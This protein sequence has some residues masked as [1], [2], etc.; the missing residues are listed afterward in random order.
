MGNNPIK[1]RVKCS[2]QHAL[3]VRNAN[4]NNAPFVEDSAVVKSARDSRCAG[5]RAGLNL[6]AA[7]SELAAMRD[8]D[9]QSVL[10]SGGQVS[11]PGAEKV[12]PLPVL[13]E[14]K[15]SR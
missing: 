7:R 15:P 2:Q 13:D 10:I 3:S 6:V 14:I 12:T 5:S 1:K 11:P 9:G 4:T 8:K